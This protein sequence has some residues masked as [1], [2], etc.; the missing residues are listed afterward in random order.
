MECNKEVGF[1]KVR[2]TRDQIA[3]IHWIIEK[4]REFQ[5]KF[6][7]C[8]IDCVRAFNWVDDHQLFSSV[9]CSVVSDS[10][11]PGGQQHTRPPCPSPTSGVAHWV[12]YA[13]QP[14]HPLS[15]PFPPTFKL[16]QHQGLSNESVIRIRWPNYWSFSFN[17]SPSN[18]Y[19]TLISF[20]MDWLGL[21]AVQ[22][23][24]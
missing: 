21:L 14:S 9:C 16:F 15:S 18:E 2:W 3:S 4:A 10:F 23:T 20:R 1:R 5:K 13:M 19:S 6:Y 24:L 22:G 8:F 11:R 7:F 12:G 17:I